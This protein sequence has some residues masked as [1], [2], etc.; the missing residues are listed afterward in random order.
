MAIILYFLIDTLLT[1]HSILTLNGKL[2]QLQQ[3]LDE[4]KATGTPLKAAHAALSEYLT[5]N[6]T[7]QNF[8]ERFSKLEK[9]SPSQRR[10]LR[11]FPTM[12][13]LRNAEP[14]QWLQQEWQRRRPGKN[15][16]K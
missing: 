2:Q 13:S 5:D 6:P 10:L 12:R 16:H 3:L 15:I 9:I 1:L 14:L 4:C 11:A 7:I 8:R